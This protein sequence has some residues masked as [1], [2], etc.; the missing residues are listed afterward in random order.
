[1][2]PPPR[3]PDE[4]VMMMSEATYE[5]IKTV[6]YHLLNMVLID[7]REERCEG[8]KIR[9][10]SQRRHECLQEELQD[11]FFGIHFEQIAERLFGDRFISIVQ[12]L[13]QGRNIRVDVVT[14][15]AVSQALLHALRAEGRVTK[16]L[17]D[18]YDQLVGTDEKIMQELR[19]ASTSW[20]RR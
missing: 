19:E 2:S 13:L 20:S 14:I 1:M 6:V 5:A 10:P 4:R 17:A 8:C 12:K 3:E 11:Y 18:M 9:H 7:H 15:Y 16:P